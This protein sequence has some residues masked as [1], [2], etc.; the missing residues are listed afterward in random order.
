MVGPTETLVQN[1]LITR[2]R[3]ATHF[4]QYKVE[5]LQSVTIKVMRNF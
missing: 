4:K 1:L 5:V 2:A 3:I